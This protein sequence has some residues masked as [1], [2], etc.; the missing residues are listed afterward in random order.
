MGDGSASSGRKEKIIGLGDTDSDYSEEKERNPNL[1]DYKDD[2]EED[3]DDDE[4][5][6]MVNEGMMDGNY[7]DSDDDD[8][9]VNPSNKPRPTF[10]MVEVS[11]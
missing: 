9:H 8:H 2:D 5:Q 4:R 11:F 3:E 7:Q 1:K 10:G 6:Y